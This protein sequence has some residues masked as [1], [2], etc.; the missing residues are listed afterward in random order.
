MTTPATDD[1]LAAQTRAI[2]D[3]IPLM[4]AMGLRVVELEPGRAVVEAP[5]E[6][7]RNHVGFVYAG[8]LFSVAEVLGGLIPFVT[9]A[10]DGYVPIVAG[11]E[12]SFLRPARTAVRATATLS[13]DDTD[14]VAAELA[15]GAERVWFSLESTVSDETEVVATTSGRYLLQRVDRQVR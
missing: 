9:W 8:A 4:A 2:H 3:S 1:D 10:C 5:F 7:N 14:R 6:P 15:D 12:I 13:R 11:V